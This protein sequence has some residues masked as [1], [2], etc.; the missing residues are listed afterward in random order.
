MKQVPITQAVKITKKRVKSFDEEK[1]YLSTGDLNVNV[2]KNLEP[3]T[4]ENRPSRADLIVDV[5]DL[6]VARMQATKKVM[7]IS[8]EEEEIIVST[9]F[10]TLESKEGWD[11][12]FLY[13]YFNSPN[14]QDQ[15]DRFC[16]GATQKAI[17]NTK[18][19]EITIPEISLEDQKRLVS[20]LREA[21]KI[22]KNRRKAIALLDQYLKSVFLEMFG[23]TA[24]NY[25]KWETIEMQDLAEKK[26]GSMRT[27][28]FGS[29]LKHSEFVDEGIAVIGID[30]AVQNKFAW[31]ERRFITKEKYQKLKRYTLY[32]D[33][34]I[35]TIMATTGRSAVIPQD[36]PLS[37]N[38]K[39]LASI[40]LDRNKANPYFI[41]YSIHS[42]P[43]ITKQIGQKNRGAIMAGLNLGIIK[44]L[45]LKYPPIKLQNKFAEILQKTEKI[46]QSMFSQSAELDT[47]FNALMQGAF[48]K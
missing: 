1:G 46:K 41:S 34:V 12:E 37:I 32:P 47:N 39:H 9:G 13:F 22:G 36:I 6:I 45:K 40:T 21:D 18:F 14:F 4:Y 26:K 23:E 33:D 19:K 31:D 27:G 7:L 15:K 16:T 44:K 17:N 24:E 2:I 28:P 3:V 25:K 29:D 43:L 38:T 35:I 11:N 48:R 10:L 5:G 20:S 42:N 8:E 30:N